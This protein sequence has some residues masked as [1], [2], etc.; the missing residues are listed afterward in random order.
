MRILITGGAGFIGGAVVRRLRARG[1]EVIA[2]VRDDRRADNLTALGAA[3]VQDDL[4]DVERLTTAVRE[5]APDAVIHAAGSYRIGIRKDERGAMWD[6]NVGTTTRMLD[7]AEAAGILSFVYVSTVNVFGNTRGR[8]VDETFR[9]DMAAG[10]LTWYDETKFG[11]HEVAEQRIAGGAPITIAMPGTVI[12][13]GDHT[14]IGTQLIAARD[15]KLPYVA[16]AELGMTPIHVDDEAAGIVA[17]L[18]RGAAGRS[19]V[20][21]GECIRFG[22]ALAV[23]ADVGARN[24]PRIRIPDWL[25]RALAPA[26][27]LIGRP[28]LREVVAASAGVTYWASSQRAKDELGF[29]P[30]DP[31]T[32]IRD[33][34][35][36]A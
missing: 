28:D 17:V 32:A 29:A 14:Q 9:R 31:G 34:L 10:F 1:D 33:T 6:A 23:A 30:R 8:I 4:S 35:G 15:G 25:L 7:A 20:L 5:E 13:P 12:G 27:P 16:S 22:D 3:L 21:A 26:G 24:L 11:A 36:A 18:D 2:F 19:Y